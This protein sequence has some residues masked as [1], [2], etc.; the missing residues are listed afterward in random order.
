MTS[1]LPQIDIPRI[2]SETAR[3]YAARVEYVIAGEGRS[4]DRLAD[5]RRSKSGSRSTTLLNWSAKYGWVESARAYDNTIATLKAQHAAQAEL[6]SYRDALENHRA[7]YQKAGQD[8]YAIASGLLSQCARA[9]KGEQIKGADGK[10]YTIPAM[11][12]TPATVSTAMR[13]LAIAADLEA[14][15]LRIAELL[16]ALSRGG[17]E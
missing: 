8:L 13:A 4:I 14:H 10:T 9:I 17:D 1:A 12:L 3:A 11:E 5:Q 7:R 15:A 16:P 6:S 2:A